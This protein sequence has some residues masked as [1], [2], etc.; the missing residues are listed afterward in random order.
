MPQCRYWPISEATIQTA[1]VAGT[2]AGAASGSFPSRRAAASGARQR[3]TTKYSATMIPAIGGIVTPRVSRKPVKWPRMPA[4]DRIVTT[5]PITSVTRPRLT[6]RPATWSMRFTKPSE[7]EY[8][9]QSLIF[10]VAAM[11]ITVPAAPGVEVT[12]V[13]TFPDR[14]ACASSTPISPMQY[15]PSVMPSTV[16]FTTSPT[17]RLYLVM[18]GVITAPTM[19]PPAT[20]VVAAARPSVAPGGAEETRAPS[21]C[22][23]SSVLM[24]QA[25]SPTN[26]GTVM[27]AVQVI[28]ANP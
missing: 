22:L 5:A 17:L 2:Q 7:D 15:S 4:A 12:I 16:C 20:S 1:I 23:V 25:Q 6:L 27:Y 18:S 8:R 3:R 21:E 10:S 24:D 28:E 13:M 9:F 19:K 26:S 14:T 11:R